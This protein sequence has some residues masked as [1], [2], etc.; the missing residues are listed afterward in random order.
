MK[1]KLREENRWG[2]TKWTSFGLIIMLFLVVITFIATINVSAVIMSNWC[3]GIPKT[4]EGEVVYVIHY[5]DKWN[6]CNW[7]CVQIQI[8]IESTDIVYLWGHE[9][10]EVGTYY[11]I[12]TIRHIERSQ[13]FPWIMLAYDEVVEV[14]SYN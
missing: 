8:T 12:Q 9:N 1:F 11:E 3:R 4:Y 14:Q 7:T 6:D 5:Y 2:N 10:F 13:R